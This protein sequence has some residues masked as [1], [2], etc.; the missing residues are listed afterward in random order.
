MGGH[1]NLVQD[2]FFDKVGVPN[3]FQIILILYLTIFGTNLTD[4][5]KYRNSEA[6]Q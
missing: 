3:T 6:L 1:F 2:D 5:W 4:A